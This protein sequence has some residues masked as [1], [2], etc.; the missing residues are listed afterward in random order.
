MLPVARQCSYK[1]FMSSQPINFKGTEGAVALI[2]WFERTESGFP[3]ETVSK[4]QDHARAPYRVSP[5]EIADY[6]YEIHYHPGK[7]NVVADAIPKSEG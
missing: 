2:C 6:D 4:M 1:E 5:S 7:A 3:V